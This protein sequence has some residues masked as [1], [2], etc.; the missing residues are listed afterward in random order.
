M[1]SK[2]IDKLEGAEK[3][4]AV[5]DH[6]VEVRTSLKKFVKDITEH[7]VKITEEIQKGLDKNKAEQEILQ[8]FMPKNLTNE[9]LESVI[10]T[11]LV[12]VGKNLGGVMKKLKT[13][14]PNRY[15]GLH[16]KQYTERK[17]KE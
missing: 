4:K 5:Q 2:G 16:A 8:E 9:E 12:E 1:D 15:D 11:Y 7:K 6:L 14:H 3:E 10:D 17:I 13:E